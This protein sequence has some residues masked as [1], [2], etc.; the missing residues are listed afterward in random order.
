[1]SKNFEMIYISPIGPIGVNLDEDKI[2]ELKFIKK[3]KSR[4]SSKK[5]CKDLSKQLDLYFK[6]KLNKFNLPYV[7]Y[8]SEYQKLVLNHV[9]NISYGNTLCYSDIAKKLNSHPRPVGNACRNNPLQLLIP[10]HRVIG[11]NNV[12][13]YSGDGVKSSGNFIY[14]KKVLLDLEHNLSIA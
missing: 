14:I 6:K 5:I 2:C 13:G 8:G 12:G 3:V 1:M 7:L 11:K 9:L 10:C 4:K